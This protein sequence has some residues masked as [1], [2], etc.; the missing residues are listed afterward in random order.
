MRGPQGEAARAGK[1]LGGQP[2]GP[3]PIIQ[4]V[5]HDSPN[6]SPITNRPRQGQPH[7]YQPPFPHMQGPPGQ[8]HQMYPNMPR[9]PNMAG[10]PNMPPQPMMPHPMMHPSMP[11]QM[12]P[13]QPGPPMMNPYPNQ[14]TV[15]NK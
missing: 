13:R 4:K 2:K 15:Y 1:N 9:M 12:Q 14:G 5:R 7:P 10:M 3:A 11:Q 8:M 6:L